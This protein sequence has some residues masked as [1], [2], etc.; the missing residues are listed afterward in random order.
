[1]EH[2]FILFGQNAA[3]FKVHRFTTLSRLRSGIDVS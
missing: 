1:M 2:I 3:I